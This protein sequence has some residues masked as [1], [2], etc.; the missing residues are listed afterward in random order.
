MSEVDAAQA[1]RDK[2]RSEREAAVR[3]RDEAVSASEAAVAVAQASAYDRAAGAT[4]LTPGDQRTRTGPHRRAGHSP[5]AVW[6]PR[7]ASLAVLVIILFVV[8]TM[9]RGV[10]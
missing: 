2:A 3:A 7:L 10:L 4:P 8:F 9:L 5:L 6:A 1:A